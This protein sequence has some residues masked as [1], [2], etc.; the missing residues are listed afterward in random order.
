MVSIVQLQHSISSSHMNS[1][2]RLWQPNSGP[3]VQTLPHSNEDLS[4]SFSQTKEKDPLFL[5]LFVN[6][7]PN[8]CFNHTNQFSVVQDK[9]GPVVLESSASDSCLAAKTGRGARI[10][11]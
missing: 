9:C 6:I 8:F 10:R 3:I 7:K 1:F 4:R 11:S 5:Q 2:A